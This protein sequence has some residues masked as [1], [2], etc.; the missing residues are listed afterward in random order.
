MQP[1]AAVIEPDADCGLRRF[2]RYRQWLAVA[3]MWADAVA[4]HIA[5]VRGDRHYSQPA[6]SCVSDARY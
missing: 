3:T 5:A 2:R 4:T 6:L 1:C